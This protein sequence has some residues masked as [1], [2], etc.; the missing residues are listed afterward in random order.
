MEQ[1]LS[2]EY[3]ELQSQI[4]SINAKGISTDQMMAVIDNIINGDLTNKENKPLDIPLTEVKDKEKEAERIINN[5]RI[6]LSSLV[7][8]KESGKDDQERS[9]L[10]LEII[11]GAA[12]TALAIL[13]ASREDI[14]DVLGI[15]ALA[16]KM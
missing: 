14:N 1:Q 10:K 6:T 16:E 7:R 11:V 8:D 2:P 3:V 9:A 13:G 4:K 5:Y 12:S 15:T